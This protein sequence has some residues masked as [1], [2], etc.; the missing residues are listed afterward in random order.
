MRRWSE[1]GLCSVMILIYVVRLLV[2]REVMRMA[3]L[4]ECPASLSSSVI[5]LSVI[6]TSTPFMT[7]DS[8]GFLCRGV[9]VVF[10]GIVTVM[11]EP[12]RCSSVFRCWCWKQCVYSVGILR[13]APLVSLKN[14]I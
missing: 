14:V 6:S 3:L 7:R 4:M 11:A 12:R 1:V 13:L 5:S 8:E 9:V 2:A 10:S